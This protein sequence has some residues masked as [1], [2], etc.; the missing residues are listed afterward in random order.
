[1]RYWARTGGICRHQSEGWNPSPA[2]TPLPCHPHTS[3]FH[4]CK[5]K[6][7]P[8]IHLCNV[9][10]AIFICIQFT[11]STN[12]TRDKIST[13]FINIFWKVIFLL[14]N[15]LESYFLLKISTFFMNIFLIIFLYH[16]INW[17]HYIFYKNSRKL[18]SK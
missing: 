14:T 10:K 11:W 4:P 15:C 7:F 5:V 12:W 13:S 3:P 8:Y 6:K 9:N 17:L 1:M 18:Q 2:P 16:N